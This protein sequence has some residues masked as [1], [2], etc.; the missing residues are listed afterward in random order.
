MFEKFLADKT[1]WDM[2]LIGPAGTGKTTELRIYVEHC[3]A[4]EIPYVVCAYTHKACEILMEKLP[5]GARIQT[6]HSFLCKRPTI[7]TNAVSHKHITNSSQT[8][9]PDTEPEVM[10]LD[11]YSMVGEKDELDIRLEQDPEYEGIPKLK[12]V[13]VGDLNQLGPVGDKQTVS[14]KGNYIRKLTKIWRNDNPLQEPLNA[15]ISYIKG[16]PPATLPGN[17]HFIRGKDLV[18]EY[19]NCEDDKVL[20]AFTNK[21]VQY[22]NSQIQG[23]TEPLE[24]DNLFCPSNRQ[25]YIFNRFVDYPERIERVHG[26]PLELNSKYKTLE[27]LHKMPEI[28]YAEVVND[29][30]ETVIL[31]C[32]F[33]HYSYKNYLDGLKK[34]AADSN[35]AIERKNPGFKA[36]AW[37]KFN[38]QHKD[39]RRR[40]KAWR[41]FLSVDECVVCLDFTH[42]LTVHKSQGSTFH[43]VFLDTDDLSTCADRNFEQYLKLTYVGISRASHKVVTN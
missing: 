12:V 35:L 19:S 29:E 1:A 22:L 13:W 25:G 23:R 6:L 34:E 38:N 10:F 21:R 27:G 11:E 3:I 36:V 9:A 41:E 39:A 26:D 37:A 32:V 17:S 5:P 20:L 28:Q 16:E 2:F 24:D 40:A 43:T 33:G 8:D 15:L 7:N 31:A 4:K 42:A 18:T 14:P 30:G